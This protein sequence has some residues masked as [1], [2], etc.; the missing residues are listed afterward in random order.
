MHTGFSVIDVLQPCVTWNK[1][2]GYEFYRERVY[3]L[4]EKHNKSNYERAI[5]KAME[6]AEDW[7]K[8]PIGIFYETY[9]PAYHEFLSQI[10]T[11]PLVERKNQFDLQKL[12]QEF[13]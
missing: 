13:K 3:K 5:L 4:D 9:R 6:N 2:F 10:K 8:L 1:G 7:E 11:K 12:I